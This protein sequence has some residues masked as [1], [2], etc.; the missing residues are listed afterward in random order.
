MHL[1]SRPRVSCFQ[2][3]HLC[4]E[5]GGLQHRVYVSECGWPADSRKK[6]SRIVQLVAPDEAQAPRGY[7]S[8]R[9]HFTTINRITRAVDRAERCGLAIKPTTTRSDRWPRA[10][11]DRY[12]TEN[13]RFP[14]AILMP[15]PWLS[16]WQIIIIIIIIIICVYYSCRQAATTTS[17]I[18]ITNNKLSRMTALVQ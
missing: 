7:I 3:E 18:N 12:T 11:S 14:A 8:T 5:H 1:W 2:T 4:Y 6:P 17:T 16:P 10:A 15:S 9:R 13:S